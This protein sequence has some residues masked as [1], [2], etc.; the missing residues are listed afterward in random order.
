MNY[1]SLCVWLFLLLTGNLIAQTY[2]SDNQLDL[3]NASFEEIL[4]LPVTSEIAEKL[5]QRLMFKGDFTSIYDLK[6]IDG[7][8]QKLLNSLK[9]LIRI[10]PFRPR[11]SLQENVEELYYRLEQ[12]SGDEGVND[13]L[14]DLWIEKS[15]RPIN[16]NNVEYDDL[17]NLQNVS[18]VDAVA[19]LNYRYDIGEIRNTR[20]LRN[21]PGLSYYGYRNARNFL[22]FSEPDPED[23]SGL[24]GRISARVD[25][26]PFFVD[27]DAASSQAGLGTVEQGLS[28]IA[29]NFVPNFYYQMRFTY[30]QNYHFGYSFL[31]RLSEPTF[32]YN[33]TAVQIPRGK[34]FFG[35]EN[36]PVGPINLR[37]L[38]LGNYS[39]SFGQG[40]VMENF[41]FFTPRKSGYGYRKR[42]SG[43]SGDI[44]RTRQFDLNGVAAELEYENLQAT[45]FGSFAK[46]DAILNTQIYDSTAG[47]G[48]NQLI[49]LNQRF[50]YALD[51]PVRGPQD[52]NLS[53]LNSVQE[54]TYGANVKY[55]LFPGTEVGVTFYE[56]A[57]DRPI[58]P[59]INEI[60]SPENLSRLV[61]TD[62]EIRMAYGF[63]ISRGTNPFW[64]KA[65]SFRRVYGFDFKTVIENIAIQGE[66]GE[67]DKG[68][69]V[70]KLGDDPKALVLSVYTQFN[71]FNIQA[72]YRNYDL[73]YDN[74]Y[75][76]SFSNY[77][78]YKGTIYEDY[79]YL[80]SALYGQLYSTNPQ[81]QAEEGYYLNTY[82]Q[83]NRNLNL[84]LEYD[85][86]T[87][88]ADQVRQYRVVG[89]LDI[90]PIFPVRIQ[91]RQKWQA[92][93]K[94]NN[95]SLGYFENF[96]FRGRMDLRLS[97][98]DNLGILYMNSNL[99]VH[100]RP[101][102]FGDLA[103]K[104]EAIGVGMTH[105]F[106]NNL[107][108]SAFVA[109]Y[110]GFFW[111]FEDTQFIVLDSQR[112]A[113]RTW[114][115]LYARLNHHIS[116]RVKY[117]LDHHKPMTNI[118]F[119]DVRDPVAGQSYNADIIRKNNSYFYLE[120]DYNF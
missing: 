59:R 48:F 36:I 79:Y 37:K 68:G 78:R 29:V 51:D 61:T 97:G 27:D 119:N 82:Y 60:V 109:Y 118:V 18:P 67:L 38:Y 42:F 110:K 66:W 6:E 54:L 13:A 74:P 12:W 24:H 47:R 86:W 17:I 120:F 83:I 7:I 8:D 105:N 112:G 56:S 80:Q 5:Y 76:R 40:V 53:W 44:S 45:F 90:R 15:L 41:D 62:N 64:S 100:P 114:W 55:S 28:D 93:D 23:V 117:T 52:Q 71:N 3:N 113:L 57:Y 58:E 21:I 20:D 95:I 16:V 19:I 102:V 108:L 63:D 31:R 11:T 72:L 10:E 34:I 87:R 94:E 101:R 9:P 26:T 69:S 75:Q 4:K 77:R 46:R 65:V 14:V 91:L 107:K 89:V 1:R 103:P 43:L 96:E 98:F 99:L 84:R 49:V 30:N 88:K 22:R 50:N 39:L 32:Y 116:M 104:S 81:P 25:N 115:S 92:R 70:F 111:N 85:T 33:S 35:L 106:N 73:G 2:S